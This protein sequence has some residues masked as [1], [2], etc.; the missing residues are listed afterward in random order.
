M[1][2]RN[3]LLLLFFP[4]IGYNQ[5]AN[6][7]AEEFDSFEYVGVCPYIIPGTT[8][9][10]T[11]QTNAG[12]GPNHSGD[13]HIYLNFQNNYVG[14]AFDRP[15]TVCVGG[16]YKISFYHRDAWGGQ[17]NTTFNIYDGNNVLLSS[18]V[19]IWNG[20]AW[21]FWESPEFTATTTTL[22]LEIVNNASN[23]GNNDMCVDDMTLSI[24]S[25]E[26]HKTVLTC[27]NFSTMDF[28]SLFSS[29]MPTNG[30]WSGP[31]SLGNG[32]LGTFD[33]S[34]AL[35]GVYTYAVSGASTC[36]TPSGTIT[37]VGGMNIDLGPDQNYCTSQSVTLNAGTGFDFYEWSTG[38]T[39][40]SITTNQSGIYHVLAGVLGENLIEHGD[41]QG[42][43]TA[44]DNQFTSNYVPGT[45]GT[46][47][48]LS[49]EGQMAITTSPSLVHNNF[50]S[51]GDHTSGSGNMFV[52]NGASTPNT[53]V[54]SQ[55]IPVEAGVN[56]H[57]SFW[58]ANAT[59]DPAVSQLQLFVNGVA[60]G[61]PN[62]T[63]VTPC[64]WSEISDVWFSGTATSAV[65]SIVNQSTA[66][67]GNDFLID[68]IFFAPY[69]EYTD[70]VELNF[71][72]STI[73]VTPNQTMCE[74]GSKTIVATINSNSGATFTYHWNNI[75][76]NVSSQTVSPATTTT[77]SVYAESS[78][79]CTTPTVNVTVNVVARQT[80]NAG[81]DQTVC[82]GSPIQLSGSVSSASNNKFWAVN[83]DNVSPT[84]IVSFAPNT[85]GLTPTATVNV[86]GE[87]FFILTEQNVA[88]G[89]VKDTVSIVVSEEIH[90]SAVSDLSCFGMQ[91]GQI[92]ILSSTAVNYSFDDQ[93][94]WVQ[95]PIQSGLAA[96]IYS[97][98]S[99][100]QFGCKKKTI[101]TINEPL[102]MQITT[103]N[104]TLVCENGTAQIQAST[105]VPNCI[106][107]WDFTNDLGD[108]QSISPLQDSVVTVYAEDPNGCQSSTMQITIAVRPALSGVI[109][110]AVSICPGYPDQLNV[111]G[112]SGGLHPYTITWSSGEVGNGTSMQIAVNPS[113]TQIYTVQITDV[114]ESSTLNLS[115]TVTV[116]PLPEPQFTS[117]ALS[118]CEPAIFT[119][120]NTTD[121]NATQFIQWHLSDGQ[122][123]QNQNEV[124]TPEMYAGN[125]DVQLIISS[126]NGCVDSI[127]YSDY[128]I[129]NP[130]PTANFSWNPSLIQMFNTEVS[131]I[132]QSEL[133]TSYEWFFESGTP[134][135]S[136]LENPKITFPDGE[137]GNYEVILIATSEFGCK[138]TATNYIDVLSEVIVYVPNS[139]T[140]DNDEFNQV[141]KFYTEGLDESDFTL[142]VYNRWGQVVWE[143]HNMDV[144]WDGTYNGQLVPTGAYSWTIQAGDRLTEAVY[145]WTGTVNVLR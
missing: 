3:F 99:E 81:L 87:Y 100:N 37:V 97:I 38:A 105:N 74:N 32:Y 68:D 23:I 83:T 43:T 138:D 62:T 91:D 72:N 2:I 39:T 26:E 17:N 86:A 77:Y 56:Y 113:Q 109:S 137:V 128:L 106:F 112:I 141:W 129:V 125:Y 33:P 27:T 143:S 46:Y 135:F 36:S 44:I 63:A 80:P 126:P 48:L 102:A 131:F 93:T 118:L 73:Q 70:T 94:T 19:V 53:V 51:C 88:C 50:S 133:A 89:T 42:G 24:C 82:L 11:P 145:N 49:N 136:S 58:A 75:P 64:I 28:F 29:N 90:T 98:W 69:C 144:F 115:Q 52:A 142:K 65:L 21:N 107:Y 127:T 13:R 116:F 22:R 59:N 85:F 31:S 92:E 6:F 119:L 16:V 1:K 134:G 9:Q 34:L 41:F 132:N 35:A 96:G 130:L 103:S 47:G 121:P 120:T 18:E 117:D 124:V 57:F 30:T 60:I 84:P 54:W 66:Q 78:D 14:P 123:Y 104:D 111:S 79:G 114:C 101:I 20:T 110:P 40:A 12:F 95:N 76:D 15:Y 61:S 71:G 10:N 5:C 67:G 122:S 4:F 8:Y 25:L 140:P 108:T 139:F 7:I 55:T 45:G